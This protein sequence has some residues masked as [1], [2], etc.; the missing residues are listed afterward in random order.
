MLVLLLGAPPLAVLSFHVSYSVVASQLIGGVNS[1][2]FGNGANPESTNLFSFGQQTGI[3]LSPYLV[4]NQINPSPALATN[5][6]MPFAT[7]PQPA[8]AHPQPAMTMPVPAVSGLIDAEGKRTR[9][10]GLTNMMVVPDGKAQRVKSGQLQHG[11]MAAAVAARDKAAGPGPSSTSPAVKEVAEVKSHTARSLL[12][13]LRAGTGVKTPNNISITEAERLVKMLA[14]NHAP[15]EVL[16][17]K[18][19]NAGREAMSVLL[20]MYLQKPITM[21]EAAACFHNPTNRC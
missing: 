14:G 9:S 3:D 13:M 6:G 2:V 11:P 7:A 19:R 21:A 10:S 17:K 5:R 8:F 4:A 1:L 16:Q 18:K 20:T 15:V 12:R